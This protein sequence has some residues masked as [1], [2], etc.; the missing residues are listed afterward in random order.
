MS[1]S[2]KT[3]EAPTSEPSTNKTSS[4]SDLATTTPRVAAT[5]TGHTAEASM[6][7]RRRG[8]GDKSEPKSATSSS[9]TSLTP[10]PPGRLP[11]GGHEAAMR[12]C[13]SSTHPRQ[14]PIDSEP[15][16]ERRAVMSAAGPIG[17]TTARIAWN[18]RPT[19]RTRD[20]C[21]WVSVTGH[22]NAGSAGRGGFFC[23]V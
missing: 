19:G 2:P 3:G 8:R 23:E 1:I 13:P 14:Q 21:T 6:L 20:L 15:H 11:P 5:R 9:I 22:P 18:L 4:P 12:P 7:C 17:V 10:T 16:A